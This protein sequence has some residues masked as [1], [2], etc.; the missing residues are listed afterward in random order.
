MDENPDSFCMCIY[1]STYTYVNRLWLFYFSVIAHAHSYTRARTHTHTH[2]HTQDEDP[3]SSPENEPVHI[4]SA[5]LFLQ[6]LTYKVSQC[7]S[8]RVRTHVCGRTQQR[9]T[10]SLLYIHTH[11]ICYAYII[12]LTYVTCVSHSM[13]CMFAYAHTH[14]SHTY[15]CIM[16]PSTH[17][18][19]LCVTLEL[20]EYLCISVMC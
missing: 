1:V 5:H 6:S 12:L 18:H 4:G 17:I 7:T 19:T 3:F 14:Y 2:T 13:Y 15:V 16:Y 10:C 11:T 8:T 20:S 9:Q